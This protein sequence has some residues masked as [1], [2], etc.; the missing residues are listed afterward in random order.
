MTGSKQYKQGDIIIFHPNPEAA[1]KNPIIHRIITEEPISTK[2]DNNP[3]Q[4][5]IENNPQDLD[6]TNISQ[7]Q[8]IGKARAKIPLIGWLKLIFFE[9]SRPSSQK[10]FC[11]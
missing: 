5:N 10:G 11:H 6:E 2:G 7:K 3:Y 9:P 8:I 4:F 1:T